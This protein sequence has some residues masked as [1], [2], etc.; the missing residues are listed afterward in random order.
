MH[1]LSFLLV[2][3]VIVS[4]CGKN[5]LPPYAKTVLA[6]GEPTEVFWGDTH[7]HTSYSPDAYFFGNATAD[8]DTAYR[9]AKGLPLLAHRDHAESRIAQN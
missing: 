8:P 3:A 5:D 7:L 9:Y 6:G 4:A 1:R 2:I